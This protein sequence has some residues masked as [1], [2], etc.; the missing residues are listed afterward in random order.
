MCR[1]QNDHKILGSSGR[2]LQREVED[3]EAMKE[4]KEM[5]TEENPEGDNGNRIQEVFHC[6]KNETCISV[7]K[8]FRLK[9]C[10]TVT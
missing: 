6:N 7:R 10:R 5:M 8:S 4:R 1:K 2:W 9:S 3:D